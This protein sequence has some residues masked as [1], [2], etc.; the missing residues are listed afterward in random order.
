MDGALQGIFELS[1]TP[2]QRELIED[3]VEK[4]IEQTF[5]KFG[6]D[7]S[8]PEKVVQLQDDLR[9]VREWRTSMTMV[10][11]AG[12]TAAIGTLVTGA[13]AALWLGVRHMLNGGGGG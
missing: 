1:L 10:R 12:L 7:L 8:T 5:L 6:I 9:Y 11:R 4:T 3:V 13:I 2:E